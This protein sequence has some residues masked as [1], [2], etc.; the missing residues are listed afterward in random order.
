[1]GRES[2]LTRRASKPRVETADGRLRD[3]LAAAAMQAHLVG[4]PELLGTARW[5]PQ[6]YVRH[7]WLVP[8]VWVVMSSRL[9]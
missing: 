7:G 5:Y 6:I 4:R 3:V 8:A 1:V 2:L 9:G